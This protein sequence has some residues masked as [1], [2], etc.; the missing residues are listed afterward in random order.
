MKEAGLIEIKNYFEMNTSEF[1]KEWKQFSE[2][3]KTWWKVEL[4]KL[5]HPD[6]E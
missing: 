2:E 5:L 6:E 3:E 1:M 4:G